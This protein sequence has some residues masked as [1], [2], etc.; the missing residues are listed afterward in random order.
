MSFFNDI[1]DFFTGTIP[2]FFTGDVADFFE[3][4]GGFFGEFWDILLQIFPIFL[5]LLLL[6]IDLLRNI[7]ALLDFAFFIINN[8]IDLIY[9]GITFLSNLGKEVALALPSVN[10]IIN[11]II[12]VLDYVLDVIK[13]YANIGIVII[14]MIPAYVGI[15]FLIN[16]INDIFS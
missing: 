8:I 14:M 1:G 15:F 9:G 13:E 5:E 3:G 7:P 16:R 6:L 2:D 10:S 4:A 11:H 12:D